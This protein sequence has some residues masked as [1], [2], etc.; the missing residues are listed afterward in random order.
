MDRFCPRSQRL[1]FWT[2]FNVDWAPSILDCKSTTKYS[3]YIW[4]NLV[5]FCGKKQYVD[6]RSS[7]ETE[8]RALVQG[9]CEELWLKRLLEELRISITVLI[10]PC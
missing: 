9:I 5:A 6:A 7:A 2:K 1:T 8:Y 10:K 4:G 3:T